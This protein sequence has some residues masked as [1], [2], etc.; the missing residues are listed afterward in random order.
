MK[1][2]IIRFIFLILIIG[3]SFGL[4]FLLMD[5]SS[6]DDLWSSVTFKS[7]GLIFG[8]QAIVFLPS[9]LFKTEHYFD[10]TGGF[11]F[12]YVLGFLINSEY[13]FTNQFSVKLIPL[14]LIIIW[15]I[16]LSS[17]LF[18]RVKRSGKDLRFDEI[19]TNFLRFLIA[20]ALQ[21]LWVFMC[22]LPVISMVSSKKSL[23]FNYIIS[24]VIFW[25][26]GWMIEVFSDIQKT[27][28]N[29]NKKNKG[30]FISSGLWSKSRHPNYFGEFILW[31]GIT[32]IA[33]PS[34]SGFQYLACLTPV[35]VYLLLNNVSGVNLLEEIAEKRWGENEDYQ[36]YKNNTPVFFP[37]IFK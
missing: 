27:R 4:S 26:V 34:F 12:I 31:L 19:K 16:R 21:G 3:F 36:N 37:K 24:G 32:I 10:L 22:L 33:F 20:W 29:A 13:N 18:I 23:S 11:T 1:N 14:V 5:T 35:F 2:T 6:G 15:A 17:F 7:W 30:K 8:I 25:I 9:F 28:F